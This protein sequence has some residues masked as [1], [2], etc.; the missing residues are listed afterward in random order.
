M[1]KPLHGTFPLQQTVDGVTLLELMLVIAMVCI[2]ACAAGWGSSKL[3]RGWHL[4][5]ASQQLYEDLKSLQARA[6]STGNFAMS[7]GMLVSR[8]H[9]LV[10]EPATQSYSAYR[11]LDQN[12][13][14][15]AENGESDRLSQT[16]LPP[17]VNYAWTSGINRRACSNVNNA[18]DEAVSFSRPGYPPCNDRPCIKFDQHGFSAMGPGAIYLS[19]GEQSLAITVTRP[20]LFTLCHWDGERWR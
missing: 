5:R 19:D 11:W 1:T 8:R 10:F 4:K 13:N 12:G 20:G 18:P 6:E 9:F 3:V 7:N 15:L 16:S 17:G 2:L 14:G